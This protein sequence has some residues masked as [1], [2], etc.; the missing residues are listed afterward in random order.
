MTPPDIVE[1]VRCGWCNRPFNYVALLQSWG[2]FEC[3]T[4][5]IVTCDECEDIVAR[6]RAASCRACELTA[7][8]PP[9]STSQGAQ[10]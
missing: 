5:G 9:P 2:V 1:S 4:C 6:R 10:G 8:A 7:P 3:T